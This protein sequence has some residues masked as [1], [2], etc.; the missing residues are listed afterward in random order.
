[1]RINGGITEVLNREA[2]RV[3][4]RGKSAPETTLR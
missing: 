2:G 3:I 4:C 1:M